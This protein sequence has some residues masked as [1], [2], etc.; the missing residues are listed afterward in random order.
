[1]EDD[2]KSVKELNSLPLDPD[3]IDPVL[4][5]ELVD[6]REVRPES[7]LSKSIPDRRS[8]LILSVLG[9]SELMNDIS[10]SISERSLNIFELYPRP[11]A[12]GDLYF[13]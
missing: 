4:L 3:R 13:T 12:N 1:M 6:T 7:R 5:S 9:L 10:V 8:V 11:L 2:E